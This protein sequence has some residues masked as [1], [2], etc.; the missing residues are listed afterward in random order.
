V[1]QA[2]PTIFVGQPAIW[3]TKTAADQ[4][5]LIGPVDAL[6]GLPVLAPVVVGAAGDVVLGAVGVE[7][8]DDVDLARVNQVR[9]LRL[10]EELVHDREHHLDGQVL[11]RVMLADVEDAGLGEVVGR[12][13]GDADADEVTAFVGRAEREDVDEARVR[14]GEVLDVP[15]RFA[16]G[17]LADV[18]AL[19]DEV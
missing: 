10:L 13:V 18:E 14:R 1:P 4:L 12:V 15:D 9:D 11:A 2:T 17:G 16:P 6:V 19:G 8:R 5:R 7:A 3:A